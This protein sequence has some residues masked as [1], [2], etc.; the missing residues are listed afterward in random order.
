[1]KITTQRILFSLSGI[2]VLICAVVVYSLLIQP[3]YTTIMDLRGQLA[4]KTDA[5]SSYQATIAQVNALSSNLG[6]VSAQQQRASMIMPLGPDSPYFSNQIIGVARQSGLTVDAISIRQAMQPIATAQSSAIKPIG[7]LEAT[8]QVTGGYSQIKSFLQ[9]IQN[10]TLLMNISSVAISV[11]SP[12]S[13][14]GNVKAASSM[15]T[16]TI[17][18]VSYYQETDQE[19]KASNLSN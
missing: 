1:M 19:T 3:A 15:L 12:N 4:A 10:N 16:G 18:I 17:S 13:T 14:M 2:V 9:A 5:V 6:D 8:V 7:N 11:A